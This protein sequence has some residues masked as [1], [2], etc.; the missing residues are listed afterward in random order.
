MPPIRRVDELTPVATAPAP[1]V[2]DPAPPT[3]VPSPS[4]APP[5]ACEAATEGGA[6][7]Q[8]ESESS[9]AEA[10][11]RSTTR[12]LTIDP[13]PVTVAE[14]AEKR[15]LCR[16]ARKELQKRHRQAA[17]REAGKKGP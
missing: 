8:G 16:R 14:D 7:V 13:E 1:A 5:V 17:H 4:V 3:V 6:E 12:P 11:A 9:P 10:P 15:P 2:A